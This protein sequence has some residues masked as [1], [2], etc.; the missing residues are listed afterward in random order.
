MVLAGNKAYVSSW[1]FGKDIMVINTN[2]DKVIDSIRVVTEPESMVIDKDNKLWIL[3]SG[4]YTGQ[5]LAE[6]IV[7]NTTTNAI[8]N[9]FV[10]SSKSSYPSG[11]Q[12]NGTKDSLYYIDN[13]LWKMSILSSALP[14]VPFKTAGNRSIYKLGVD[15][16]NQRV[17]FT[18]AIDYQQKGFVLQL[19]SGG[20][21]IDS[22]SSDIIPGSFCFK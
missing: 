1:S 19:N 2:T 8:E 10:F 13:G 17:F 9:H 14:G 12:I 16:R 7:V 6:L 11:L 20:K 5:I 21:L 18:N 22:C 3:C 4:G 15:Q